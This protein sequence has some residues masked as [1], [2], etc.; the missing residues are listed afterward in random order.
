[1]KETIKLAKEI[2]TQG[3]IVKTSAN[4]FDVL[5]EIVR[6][7]KKPGRTLMTCSCKSCSR[8]IN[9]PNNMCSRKIAVVLFEAQEHKLKQLI[10]ENMKYF[11]DCQLLGIAPEVSVAIN[12]L[13]DLRSFV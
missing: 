3:K 13:N 9:E 7:E 8:N 1:M 12:L 6:L 11:E 4:Y 5:D 2:I 10:R